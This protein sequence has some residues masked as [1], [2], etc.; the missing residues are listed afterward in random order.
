MYDRV[1]LDF[2]TRPIIQRRGE[3][4]LKGFVE[5][6]FVVLILCSV[7]G[8]LFVVLDSASGT[9]YFNINNLKIEKSLR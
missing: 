7:L 3:Q 5:V 6:C 4:M 8:L 9:R 2:F 1:C